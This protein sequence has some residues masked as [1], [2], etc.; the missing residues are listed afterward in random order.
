MVFNS[1]EEFLVSG[2]GV[3]FWE[4][5]IKTEVETQNIDNNE[6]KKRALREAR[7]LRSLIVAICLLLQEE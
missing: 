7:A 2:D 3:C 1:E 5:K 6:E 4:L